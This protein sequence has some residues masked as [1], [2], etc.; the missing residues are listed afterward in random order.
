MWGWAFC[1][2][3]QSSFSRPPVSSV[4]FR[5]SS[6]KVSHIIFSCLCS[7][8]HL[9]S[10]MKESSCLQNVVHEG[11]RDILHIYLNLFVIVS[12][13]CSYSATYDIVTIFLCKIWLRSS[14]FATGNC[15]SSF[16]EMVWLSFYFIFVFCTQWLNLNFFNI[17]FIV[18]FCAFLILLASR[19]NQFHNFSQ[20]QIWIGFRPV[21][22]NVQ[23]MPTNFLYI[24]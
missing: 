4:S 12:G 18:H 20:E 22:S 2:S 8:V 10:F 3:E 5:S 14:N 1:H 9:F 6:Q 7:L 24:L 17:M 19:N 15:F 16:L 13:T 11:F 21:S 23:Q